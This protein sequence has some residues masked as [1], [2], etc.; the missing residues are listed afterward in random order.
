MNVFNQKNLDEK[1]TPEITFKRE[2]FYLASYTFLQ[3]MLMSIRTGQIESSINHQEH[4]F[5]R[6]LT[7][8]YFR[9]VYIVKFSRTAFS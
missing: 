2:T 9:P 7:T 5:Y 1:N 6:T 4:L 3:E 8:S